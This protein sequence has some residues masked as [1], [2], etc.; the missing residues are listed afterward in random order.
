MPGSSGDNAPSSSFLPGSSHDENMA[1][2][3]FNYRSIPLFSTLA[4]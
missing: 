1:A 2:R 3:F 4:S